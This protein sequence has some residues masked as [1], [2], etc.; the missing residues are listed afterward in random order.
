MNVF[1]ASDEDARGQTFW[2]IKGDDVD[3]FVLDL[4]L[5]RSHH[6][7]R[8]GRMSRCAQVQCDPDYENPTDATT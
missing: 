8:E 5:S 3:D 7:S 4:Q 1:T 6:R 2:T